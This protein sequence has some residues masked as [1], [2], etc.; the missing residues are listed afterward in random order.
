MANPIIVNAD[1]RIPARAITMRAARA[2]G[3]GGQNVNKVASKVDL[4]VDLAAIEGLSPAA[5][6]RLGRMARHRLDALGRLV[7]TSQATRDQARNLDD[8]RA[9]VRSL[10]AAALREP[11]VRRATRPA[12]GAREARLTDKKRRAQVK[13]ARSRPEPE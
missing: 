4:R 1:V 12:A 6:E 7:V 10:V 13:R 2:S 9:K 8:A 3:P 5:H 11:R